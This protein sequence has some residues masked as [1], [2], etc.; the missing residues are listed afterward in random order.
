MPLSTFLRQTA[1]PPQR[2]TSNT[3]KILVCIIGI[4][5]GVLNQLVPADY[6]VTVFFG[7]AIACCAW[8]CSRKFMWALTSVF[9]G[10][11]YSRLLFGSLPAG[12]WFTVIL[13][14]SLTGL[15]LLVVAGV[16]HNWMNDMATVEEQRNWTRHLVQSLDQ[17]QVILRKLDGTIIL[18]SQGAERMYGWSSEQA[19]GKSTH[20]LFQTDFSNQALE[21][22]EQE[23][24][25]NGA[26]F[27]ELCHIRKDGR[28]LWVASQWTLQ[29]KG[30]FPYPVVTEVN[31]DITELKTAENRFRNLTEVLPHLVW[32][33]SPDGKTT[34][35][36]QRWLE[37][38]GRKAEEIGDIPLSG[39]VHPD[40]LADSTAR[41]TKARQAGRMEPW[42]VRYRRHDGT[43]RWFTGRAAPVKNDAGEILYW[44]G[45]ATDVEEE[46]RVAERLRETQKLDSIGRLA[47]GVAHDFNNLLTA[48]TGYNS[49]LADE[50]A[51]NPAAVGYSIEIGKAV[52]RASALTTQLLSFSR[53]QLAK[54]KLVNLNNILTDISKILGRVIGEDIQLSIRLSPELPNVLA[55]PVQLDQIVMNLAV[56]ARDAMPDG[57]TL[58]LETGTAVVRD[59]EARENQVAPGLHVTLT[60]RDNG[61]GMDEAIRLRLFEPFFTTKAKGKG[62]GLGLSIV[63]GVVKHS[64]GFIKVQSAPGEGA[65]FTIYLPA[66]GEAEREENHPPLQRTAAAGTGTILVVEDE[67]SVRH[68]VRASLQRRGYTVLD[69]STPGAGIRLA[70]DYAAPI[71]L[72]ISDVLMPEMRGPELVS[73]VRQLRPDLSVLYMSGYSDSTFLE[74]SALEGASYIQK[75]FQ[76][77]QLSEMVASILNARRA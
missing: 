23:L 34:F 21:E 41:W 67:D 63:S 2:L 46:K 29:T 72:V 28:P 71:D 50:V 51:A 32:Q 39:L 38:F 73:R 52:E 31:N 45:T 15:A 47:G 9:L 40:D 56:N 25:K 65:C 53:P 57:G 4:L 35:A 13:N 59:E 12:E 49:F 24:L 6:N 11:S 61:A 27:G 18:W 16:V 17:A 19:I 44:I 20:T 33:T 43:Y 62:T 64:G 30:R 58:R 26:W 69:A 7:L 75:P 22:I 74:P 54:P 36:N 77:V 66:A 37:Y 60:A 5:V 8:T 48:I 76:P 1:A 70:R 68:L 10:L 3:A 42:E 55:D 14:R